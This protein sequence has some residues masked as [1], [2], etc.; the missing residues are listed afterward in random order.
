MEAKLHPPLPRRGV[1][2][3]E[4]LVR[5]LL[6]EPEPSIVSLMAPPGYGK[7]TLLT[8]WAARERRPVAWLTIDDLDNDPAILLSYL[9]VAL[10][11]IVPLDP[12][13]RSRLSAPRERIL[14]TAVPRLA[15]ELHAWRRPA[16]LVIDDV[17]QLVDRTCL[18]ALAS[19]IDH[20]PP[21]FSIAIAGRSEPG[22]PLARHRARGTM[23]EIG[24]DQ[25]ALD[26]GETGEVV[27]AVGHALAPDEARTLMLRTE[28]W[29]AAVYLAA[30]ARRPGGVEQDALDTVSGRDPYIDAYLRSEIERDLGEEDVAFL[31]RTAVLDTMTPP[32]ADAITGTTG[33]AR[34]LHAL[35]RSN[36]LIQEVGGPEPSYRYHNLLRDHLLAELER[37][38]PGVAPAMHGRAATWYA[39][40]GDVDR[41]VEH[42]FASGD[43]DAAAGLVTA[44]ALPAFYEGRPNTLDRWLRSFGPADFERNPP[45][46]VIAAWIHVLNGRTDATDRM[47]DVAD[48]TLFTGVPGDGSASF[49]SQRAMLWAI[50]ARHGA[51]DVLANAELAA[52]QEGARSPWRTNALWLLGSAHYL[53]GD[54]GAADTTLAQAVDS[55]DAAAASAMVAEANRASIAMARGDW[56]AAEQLARQSRAVLTQANHD[57]L[58]SSLLVYA[59]GARVSIH[60]GDLD[61]GREDLARA[62]LVRPLASHVA[63]WFAVDALLE[64][65]RAYLAI[66]DPE[67]ARVVVQQAEHILR[68]RPDL[69]R[70]TGDV[71][72]MRR[73]LADAAATTVGSSTLTNAELR[74][75]PLLTTYLSFEEIGERLFISRNT[76]KTH[77]MSIYGKLQA[78]S[79]REAV[80]RAVELGLLE[81]FQDLRAPRT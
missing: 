24:L 61:R 1:V 60:L 66:S 65:A 49:E 15:A 32:A 64:L 55:G 78:S 68:H 42:A 8:Q 54:A 75:L 18:D 77:S 56:R 35:A 59:V 17:H 9:A 79:R 21:G 7:T 25:L 62:Q 33:A 38:E 10:D 30:L 22:L 50:L 13:I 14:A 63:P 12:S 29:A 44:A 74:L 73:R 43:L 57:E 4:R 46:A 51:K 69:G 26:E 70:L 20:L 23:L 39:A 28:G 34:R 40:M 67:G 5:L 81:P 3:R 19:L 47:A 41:A 2:D 45:L 52:S 27:A 71:I 31:T 58:L 53:L 36:L 48:H 80:E 11:R 6:T 37:R 16:L 76:V 72:E